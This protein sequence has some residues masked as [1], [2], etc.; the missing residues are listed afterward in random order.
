M[1]TE[2]SVRGGVGRGWPAVLASIVAV[3]LLSAVLLSLAFRPIE[4]AVF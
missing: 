3:G 1:V 4:G 2:T